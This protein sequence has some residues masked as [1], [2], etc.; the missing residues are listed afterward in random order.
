[1]SSA[2]V[3]ERLIIAWNADEE[4]G[5]LPIV[6]SSLGKYPSGHS[7][8]GHTRRVVVDRARTYAEARSA[9]PSAEE[10]DGVPHT[11]PPKP[12]PK[13]YNPPFQVK[14]CPL[15]PLWLDLLPIVA[16]IVLI[17]LAAFL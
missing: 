12:P 4:H 3:P 6:I 9:Y 5:G 10:E 2:E 15:P 7:L 16:A 17:V 11:R 1:M 13:Y 8:A 14:L